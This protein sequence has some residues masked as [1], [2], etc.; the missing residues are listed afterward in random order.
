[1][2]GTDGRITHKLIIPSEEG[3]KNDTAIVSGS[4]GKISQKMAPEENVA[5]KKSGKVNQP[6]EKSPEEEYDDEEEEEVDTNTP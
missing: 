4:E 5:S 1:M 6:R 2:Y 3:K